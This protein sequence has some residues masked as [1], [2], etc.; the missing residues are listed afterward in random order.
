MAA[1]LFVY[2]GHNWQ[3]SNK[4]QR[5]FVSPCPIVL[6]TPRKLKLEWPAEAAATTARLLLG[7]TNPSSSTGPHAPVWAC[8]V[9]PQLP[10]LD[11]TQRPEATA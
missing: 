5:P 6:Q 11:W 2:H 7:C 9:E 10:V 8:G 1:C 4:T 3:E